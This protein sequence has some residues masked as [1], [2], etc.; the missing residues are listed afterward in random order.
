MVYTEHTTSPFRACGKK[1]V[2]DL[3]SKQQCHFNASSFL[4]DYF[5]LATRAHK[6]S[7]VEMTSL[8]L[9][10]KCSTTSW[11]IVRPT[12]PSQTPLPSTKFSTGFV[13]GARSRSTTCQISLES[14][15]SFS[16]CSQMRK[17]ATCMIL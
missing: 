7:V 3:F 8:P 1:T 11:L 9:Q 13:D 12:T 5:T 15:V 6:K 2:E 17:L 4:Y 10:E 16:E 14:M